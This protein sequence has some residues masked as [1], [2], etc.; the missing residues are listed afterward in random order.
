M[1]AMILPGMITLLFLLLGCAAGEPGR[2]AVPHPSTGAAAP[3]RPAAPAADPEKM[4]EEIKSVIRRQLDAFKND[5]Y[6]RAYIFVSKAFRKEFPRDRFETMI[7]ARF[8]EM[9]RS[10]QAIFRKAQIDP[11]DA[12]A[13]LEVDVAGI[14]ARLASI[15]Y[16]MVFEEGSWKIDRLERLD[17]FRNL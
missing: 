1:S 6:T 8:K 4:L 12:R 14:N 11:E 2:R 5:D 16:R 13:V 3:T 17:P 15:E 10:A 7:R 9:A